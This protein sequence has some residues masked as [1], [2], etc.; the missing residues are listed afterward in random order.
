MASPAS[1]EILTTRYTRKQLN[2]RGIR[3]RRV[4]HEMNG[5]HTTRKFKKSSLFIFEIHLPLSLKFKLGFQANHKERIRYG[6]VSDSDLTHSKIKECIMKNQYHYD[7][8]EMLA[9]S[10]RSGWTTVPRITRRALLHGN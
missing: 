4:E 10:A 3:L 8:T 2:R 5:V 9:E 7:M 1:P 6:R